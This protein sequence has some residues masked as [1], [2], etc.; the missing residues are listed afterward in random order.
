MPIELSQIWQLRRDPR[1]IV[2]VGGLADEGCEYLA[3][4]TGIVN[5]SGER[6]QHIMKDHKDLTEIDII[7]MSYGL[8]HGMFASDPRDSKCLVVT[9]VH[10]DTQV[11][12][13]IAVKC[14]AGGR[15]LWVSSFHRMR[16]RQTSALLKRGKLIRKHSQ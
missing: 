3:S 1:C 14:A 4:S 7:S 10:P 11:R 13:K 2:F 8:Q 5:I 9:Y 6:L 12:Y 16:K 15:E